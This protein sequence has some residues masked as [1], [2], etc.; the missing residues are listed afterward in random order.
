MT[1][2]TAVKA[3]NG[4]ISTFTGANKSATNDLGRRHLP[5]HANTSSK[6][7]N[8]LLVSGSDD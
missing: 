8:E 7:P 2:A 3:F 1:I 6:N 5:V 4:D